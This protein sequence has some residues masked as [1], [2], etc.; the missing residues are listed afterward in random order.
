MKTL[1]NTKMEKKF[2]ESLKQSLKTLKYLKELTFKYDE[3]NEELTTKEWETIKQFEIDK[4]N[5]LWSFD[6]IMT[7]NEYWDSQ[8]EYTKNMINKLK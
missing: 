7:A 4:R 2:L 1:K 8:I 5:W 6:R 3:T